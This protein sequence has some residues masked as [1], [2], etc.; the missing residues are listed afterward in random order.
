[1]NTSKKIKQIAG[2][3]ILLALTIIFGIIGNYIQVGPVSFNLSLLP[4][5][6]GAILYGPLAGLFIGIVNGIVVLL[7]PSTGIFLSFNLLGTILIVLVKTGLAGLAS[8]FL[9]KL[10]KKFNF[11]VAIILSCIIVPIINTAIFGLGCFTVF[12]GLLFN[13]VENA[14]VYFCLGI[15]GW[16]FIFEIT[17]SAV[18]SPTVVTVVKTIGKKYDIGVNL[19]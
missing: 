17:A 1:M 7:S 2:L 18:L 14:F 11:V 3:G 4:I 5:S 9:F 8:G 19:N 15:V 12:S 10:L 16:N 13:G 6:I